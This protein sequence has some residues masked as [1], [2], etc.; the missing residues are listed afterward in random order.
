MTSA[1]IIHAVET[2]IAKLSDDD[3]VVWLRYSATRNLEYWGGPSI[4]WWV[5]ERNDIRTDSDRLS[6][7]RIVNGAWLI[8]RY[9]DNPFRVQTDFLTKAQQRYTTLGQAIVGLI[10]SP[11]T[12]E[13][14]A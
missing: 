1:Q 13:I 4:V 2:S 12:A 9:I 14:V 11:M 7:V 10:K 5:T 6:V 3:R 8:K